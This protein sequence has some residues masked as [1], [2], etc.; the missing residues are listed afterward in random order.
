MGAFSS[1]SYG[2]THVKR[3]AFFF[4]FLVKS[5]NYTQ[6]PEDTQCGIAI[7][8]CGAS[9]TCRSLA[10]NPQRP[11][12]STCICLVFFVFSCED[13]CTVVHVRTDTSEQ[14]CGQ[15]QE[16]EE[17]GERREERGERREERGERREERRTDI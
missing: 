1:R 14:A 17:R 16:V 3:G 13:I 5:V 6:Q 12:G 8:T 9:V 15:M 2:D 11:P 4:K 10:S 7:R